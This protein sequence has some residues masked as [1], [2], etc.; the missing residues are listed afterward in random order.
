MRTQ[1]FALADCNNF[2]ASCERVFQPSLEN[3]PIIV[4][5]NN[6]GCVIA[7]SNESKA[8]GI[9][10]GD[11]WFEVETLAK[12]HGIRVFSS[13]FALYGDMSRR[14]M[15]ILCAAVPAAEV[16]SIDEAF[17]DFSGREALQRAQQLVQRVRQWTGIPISIGIAPTQTLAKLANATAKKRACDVL[18]IDENQRRQILREKQLEDIWGV[19]NRIARRLERYG[20]M[21]ALQLSDCDDQWLLRHFPVTLLRTVHELRGIACAEL[22]SEIPPRQSICCSRSFKNDVCS[23][24]DLEEAVVSFTA[25]A[26]EKLRRHRRLAAN[27]SVFVQTSPFSSG[28]QYSRTLSREL[29]VPS[30]DSA[31]LNGYAVELVETLY[32]TGFRYKKA[33]V[34][35]ADLKL[36]SEQQQNFFDPLSGRRPQRQQLMLAMDK[37]NARLGNDTLRFL[38][39]GIARPWATR[40]ELL[41]PRYTTCWHELPRVR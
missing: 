35:M 11:A 33:G 8:L 3:V 9:K 27:I 15:E 37:I 31:E 20:I 17:L 2:Y 25:R 28:P 34:L 39:S 41:S 6:D 21:T 26:A 13:N 1:L 19:G 22:E 7:R 23:R 5:S 36:E 29:P 24:R 12:I 16:Y 32:K 10:M 14:V 40:R 18:L 30:S 4:L 38:G